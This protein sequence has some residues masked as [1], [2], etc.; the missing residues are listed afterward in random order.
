MSIYN[1]VNQN[2]ELFGIN[3]AFYLLKILSFVQFHESKK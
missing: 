2:L 3:Y 1:N